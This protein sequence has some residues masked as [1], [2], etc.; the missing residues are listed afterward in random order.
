MLYKH[1]IWSY[2]GI[3]LRRNLISP[4]V[5]AIAEFILSSG[6]KYFSK[7]DVIRL[8]IWDD[9]RL[10]PRVI[11]PQLIQENI[12]HSFAY[13]GGEIIRFSYDQM[14]D[15]FTAKA[16]FSKY[17]TEEDI[18]EFLINEVL[19]IKDGEVE[20]YEN[21]DLFV[22]CCSLYAETYKKECLDIIEVIQ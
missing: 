19:A 15:Y 5:N 1:R 2:R 12:L 4:I 11:I 18:R 14:N 13:D 22:A 6:K 21:V 8:P 10:N 20:K 3:V 17:T 7:E 9:Y 16:I